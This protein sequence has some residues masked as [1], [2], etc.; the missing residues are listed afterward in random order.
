LILHVHLL[1]D[2]MSL[3]F[4]PPAAPDDGHLVLLYDRDG[5][6]DVVSHYIR[7]LKKQRYQYL[8]GIQMLRGQ[9]LTIFPAT[10]RTWLMDGDKIE[11][12]GEEIGIEV[13]HRIVRVFTDVPGKQ[14]K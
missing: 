13:L 11:F 12:A 1:S 2:F 6:R 9:R 7:D 14:E 3:R 8:D 10:G 4:A 5:T